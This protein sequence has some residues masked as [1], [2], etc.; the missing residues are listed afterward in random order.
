M[1]TVQA[2]FS[3]KLKQISSSL[4]PPWQDKTSFCTHNTLVCYWKQ[5]RN[6]SWTS[7]V[8]AN[9]G[10]IPWLGSLQKQLWL[11]KL[12]LVWNIQTKRLFIYFT[13]KII[14]NFLHTSEYKNQTSQSLKETGICK[15]I[16][17][18]SKIFVVYYWKNFAN[19]K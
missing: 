16:Q 7:M 17:K 1:F 15:K 18:G 14:N 2:H 4:F 19:L 13:C 3:L 8:H 9:T 11:L 5:V 6:Q 12:D 10:K